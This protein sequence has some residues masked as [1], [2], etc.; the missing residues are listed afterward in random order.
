MSGDGLANA[1]IFFVGIGVLGAVAIST[2]NK[3]SD[4]SFYFI[5]ENV[6]DS[7]GKVYFDT[8]APNNIEF[9]CQATEKG[10]EMM[11]LNKLI[12]KI[13]ERK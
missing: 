11:E 9:V 12:Q 3:P 4:Y 8:P 7:G 13:K 5:N 10:K 1:V 2:Y 6:I